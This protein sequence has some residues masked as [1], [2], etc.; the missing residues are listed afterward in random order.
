V[1]VHMVAQNL[2]PQEGMC[3][4]VMGMGP[5]GSSEARLGGET[6]LLGNYRSGFM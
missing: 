6:R 5:R 2:P 3:Y 4:S 1:R